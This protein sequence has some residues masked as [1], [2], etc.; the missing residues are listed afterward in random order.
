MATLVLI[1]VSATTITQL[2]N[3]DNHY[4]ITQVFSPNLISKTRDI[5][6]LLLVLC[7]FTVISSVPLFIVKLSKVRDR[8]CSPVSFAVVST[9]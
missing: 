3:V 9:S 1:A 5:N 2:P 4:E 6:L 8:C 7:T